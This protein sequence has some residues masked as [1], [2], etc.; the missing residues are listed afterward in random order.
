MK[1]EFITEKKKKL[2]VVIDDSN[3]INM[4]A[5]WNEN[6]VRVKL[7]DKKEITDLASDPEAFK[8]N[9][10]SK[11][12]KEPLFPW[13]VWPLDFFEGADGTFI[14]VTSLIPGEFTPLSE[15]MNGSKKFK[16]WS[17]MYAAALE[18]VWIFHSLHKQG[19]YFLN[20]T[21]EDILIN[22]NT[23]K[24]LLTG[25]EWL[26]NQKE[27]GQLK[28]NG[29]SNLVHPLYYLG[30]KEPSLVTDEYLLSVLLFEIL[31]QQHPLEGHNVAKYPVLNDEY[32]KKIYGTDP[33]FI[34]DRENDSNR[35]VKGVHL[36]VTGLWKCCPESIK[37]KFYREFSNSVMTYDVRGISVSVWYEVLDHV[38]SSLYTDQGG[39]EK[40]LMESSGKK[41]KSREE[42][43]KEIEKVAP[44]SWKTGEGNMG[45]SFFLIPG[46]KIYASQLNFPTLSDP[47][48]IAGEIARGEN[49]KL[50][51][52]LNK[53][54]EQWEAQYEDT[55]LSVK[56]GETLLAKAGMSVQIGRNKIRI[57]ETKVT[58]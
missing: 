37:K 29:S 31:C 49:A 20:M 32:L 58:G 19:Y 22:A 35:P 51:Y 36:M 2:V 5:I 18:L 6:P 30:K 46:N 12:N 57:T 48:E 56:P 16:N 21:N 17:V 15:Y 55:Q 34:F 42:Q 44:L 26:K 1:R 3:R 39:V 9:I 25:A 53:T 33:L 38:R 23:G 27:S 28:I 41:L 40:I 50:C 45:Q 4:K 47:S 7:F 43:Q 8:K 10:K 54:G 11:V 13:L 24:V 14:Y 52:I